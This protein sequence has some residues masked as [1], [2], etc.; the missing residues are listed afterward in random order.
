M[1]NTRK[2]KWPSFPGELNPFYG[3]THSEETKKKISDAHFKRGYSIC[4]G[5]KRNNITK[6]LI[7][8]E[9][10]EHHLGRKLNKNE[11]VHHINENRMDNSVSNL[12]ILSRAEH[13]KLHKV[14]RKAFICRECGVEFEDLPSK[15]RIFCSHKCSSVSAQRI[16]KR[17]C[18]NCG[19]EFFCKPSDPKRKCSRK[20][21]LDYLHGKAVNQA[22]QPGETGIVLKH[23]NQRGE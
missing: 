23:G 11:I 9:I 12:I 14:K 19:K 4:T 15:K 1:K 10:M 7:H 8:R 16:E 5:Y 3:K 21:N 18:V 20:C 6:G 2:G 17:Y 22:R 13:I